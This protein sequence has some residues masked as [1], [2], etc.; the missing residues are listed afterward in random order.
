MNFNA[1]KIYSVSCLNLDFVAFSLLV[2][3][4]V[5]NMVKLGLKHFTFSA[6]KT[7]EKSM[8]K[9]FHFQLLKHQF[10]STG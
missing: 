10:F 5:K 1:L 8:L 7:L 9:A 4:S 2:K 3:K 6:E